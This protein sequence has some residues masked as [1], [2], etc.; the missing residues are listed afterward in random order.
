MNLQEN[1]STEND[2]KEND[3]AEHAHR[4]LFA[5]VPNAI[6]VGRFVGSLFLPVLAYNG[7]PTGFLIMALILSFSDWIDGKIAIVFDQRSVYGARLDSVA[8]LTMYFGILWGLIVLSGQII[9]P[10]KWWLFAALGSYGVTIGFAYWKYGRL[11]SYHT[12]GAKTSW[13]LAILAVVAVI[14]YSEPRPLRF[15]S[16]FVLIT[17]IETIIMTK[18]LPTWHA[19]V[20]TLWHALKL[21]DDAAG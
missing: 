14:L 1:D 5:T 19:D 16:A 2:S 6:C 21:K 13:F 8:D 17:N 10:E 15:A 4:R 7:H 9:W 18:V 12:R 20:L 3:S 11:P